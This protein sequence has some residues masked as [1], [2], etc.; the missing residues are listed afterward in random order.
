MGEEIE[1]EVLDDGVG[2]GAARRSNGSGI[3]L[4]NVRQRLDRMYDEGAW[5]DLSPREGAGT[6]ARV[7]IPLELGE[8]SRS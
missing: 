5:L 1:L 4:R 8:R 6:R 3:G 7:R 2:I